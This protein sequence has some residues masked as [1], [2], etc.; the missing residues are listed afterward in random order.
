MFLTLCSGY[1]PWG[2]C[3]VVC[4]L[5]TVVVTSWPFLIYREMRL[6]QHSSIEVRYFTQ[7]P[8]YWGANTNTHAGAHTSVICTRTHTHTHTQL[9]SN[10][11][12]RQMV[13]T[14]SSDSAGFVPLTT[15][16][17]SLTHTHCHTDQG[18]VCHQHTGE[19]CRQTRT[20]NDNLSY[21]REIM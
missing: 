17:Y 3:L 19:A 7:I 13:S 21:K 14:S 5:Q 12:Q 16:L 11:T 20:H 4:T 15:L 18:A 6:E 8:I 2:G 9:L 10:C 1:P